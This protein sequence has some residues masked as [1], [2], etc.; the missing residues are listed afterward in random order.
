MAYSSSAIMAVMFVVKNN[1][2]P[3]LAWERAVAK[4]FPNS[5]TSQQKGCPRSTFLGLCED[6]YIKEVNLGKYTRSDLN[7]LYGITAIEILSGNR[8]KRF[9]NTD[10]WKAV[11]QRLSITKKQ[12][13]SQ[14]NVVLALWNEGLLNIK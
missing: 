9:S 14:M 8:T 6:G 13:N 7:K 2:P 11:L 4:E 5:I 12:H 3:S 1:L 10:L